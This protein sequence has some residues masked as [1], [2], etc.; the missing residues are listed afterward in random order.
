MAEATLTEE[1]LMQKH[2]KERKELQGI[3]KITVFFILRFLINLCD[4]V[5]SWF[6]VKAF[7]QMWGT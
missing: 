6:E 1:E 2:K 5:H 7:M 3:Q 4:F